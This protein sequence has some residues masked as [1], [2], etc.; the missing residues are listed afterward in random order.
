MTYSL[1]AEVVVAQGSNLEVGAEA[2][3]DQE[4][5]GQLRV[6]IYMLQMKAQK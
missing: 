4:K 2:E 1:L 5:I 6:K 3:E